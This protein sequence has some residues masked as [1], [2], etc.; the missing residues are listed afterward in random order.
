MENQIKIPTTLLSLVKKDDKVIKI[1]TTGSLF[2]TPG[3]T[4]RVVVKELRSDK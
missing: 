4:L 1:N 2:E 3:E